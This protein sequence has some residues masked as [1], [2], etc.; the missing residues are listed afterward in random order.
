VEGLVVVSKTD[1]APAREVAALE[2]IYARAGV[3]V[4]KVCAPRGEGLE[5][6][7]ARFRG[8]TSVLV[9]PSGAGKSTLLQALLGPG[10]PELATGRVN[11]KT[12]KGRHTTTAVRLLHFPGGGWV[13]DTPGVRTLA[14]PDLRPADLPMFFPDL[15]PFTG[16]C[17][18]Q[19]C[20][21]RV[22]PGCA[23]AAAAARG[24]IDPRRLDSYRAMLATM[25]EE[26][27]RR[28]GW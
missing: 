22:E 15:A 28:R 23:A 14:V 2:S 11:A 13:V 20:T 7:A 21:H 18:F 24:D 25:I 6:L 16:E 9:G 8:R 19:D 5:A 26:A 27:E 17:R 3:A 10:S 12:G 4:V 1:L